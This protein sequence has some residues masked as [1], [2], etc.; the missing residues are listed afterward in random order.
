MNNGR[1][2]WVTPHFAAALM[3]IM[4]STAARAVSPV[5]VRPESAPSSQGRADDTDW[6]FYNR[7]PTGMRFSALKEINANNVS[8]LKEVCRIHVSG[9]GPFSSSITM[10][11][12]PKCTPIRCLRRMCAT[13]HATSP[14]CAD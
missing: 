3:L 8:K 12:C 5:A 9:P 13:S 14:T 7:E 4:A 6:P 1:T 10:V 2:A 11:Q